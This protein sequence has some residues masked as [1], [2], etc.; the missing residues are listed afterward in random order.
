MLVLKCL[1]V[2]WG[3]FMQIAYSLWIIQDRTCVL[4]ISVPED[5]THLFFSCQFSAYIWSL[6]KL[7]LGITSNQLL[8]LEEEC[9]DLAQKVKE[10]Y[11]EI[12]L[13]RLVIRSA[14]IFGKREMKESF[15]KLLGIR[16]W[17]LEAFMKTFTLCSGHVNGRPELHLTLQQSSATGYIC[18]WHCTLIQFSLYRSLK[19]SVTARVLSPLHDCRYRHITTNKV[20]SSYINKADRQL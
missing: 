5:I 16:L 20:S 11:K 10:R 13:A 4:C 2:S 15:N 17:C 19:L 9:H 18:F 7:K 8:S 14:V 1:L 12:A 3:L 6:C